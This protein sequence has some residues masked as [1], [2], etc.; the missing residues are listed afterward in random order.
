DVYRNGSLY[1]NRNFTALECKLIVDLGEFQ[2]GDRLVIYTTDS[3]KSSISLIEADLDKQ[4]FDASMEAMGSNPW[5]ITEAKDGYLKGT[6][7]VQA[8]KM[9]LFTTI[10][11]EKGWNIYVD[12]EKTAYKGFYNAFIQIPLEKEGM[13]EVEMI[14]RAPGLIPGLIISAAALILFI[15]LC[16]I[17]KKKQSKKSLK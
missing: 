2:K 1:I 5:V 7:Q 15:I 6:V 9:T 3:E 11:Y 10:P 12:G 16:L 14:Y 4:A 8:S 13:H 17:K